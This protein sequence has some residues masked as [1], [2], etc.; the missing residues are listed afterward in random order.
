MSAVLQQLVSQ[1]YKHG[2]VTDIESETAPRG[3]SEDVIRMISAKKGEPDWLLQ[4]R[5]EAY[6][7]WLTMT[8]PTWQNVSSVPS[9]RQRWRSSLPTWPASPT[10]TVARPCWSQRP[11]PDWQRS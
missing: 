9:F 6:R 3:L 2:F 7:H 10:W 4:F 11:L 1:P 5:L 8:E